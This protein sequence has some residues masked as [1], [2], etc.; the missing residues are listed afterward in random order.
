MA[1]V[2]PAK[3]QA[4][5]LH[6]QSR[7]LALIGLIMSRRVEEDAPPPQTS[8]F[9]VLEHRFRIVVAYARLR[10]AIRACELLQGRDAR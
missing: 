9:S 5:L 8:A 7:R 6:L 1:D 3:L 4:A 10:L 2:T